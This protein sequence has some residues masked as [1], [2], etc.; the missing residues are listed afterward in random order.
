MTIREIDIRY[1]ELGTHHPRMGNNTYKFY[2]RGCRE[3][4]NRSL[5]HSSSAKI[6]VVVD[7]QMVPSNTIFVK[8]N[9]FLRVGK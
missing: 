2:R 9:W 7:A 5:L 6:K 8:E 3:I 4:F 1:L